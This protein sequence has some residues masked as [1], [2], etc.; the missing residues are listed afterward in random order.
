MKLLKWYSSYCFIFEI[1]FLYVR[2]SLTML[3]VI[4]CLQFVRSH[5]GLGHIKYHHKNGTNCFPAW[6]VCVSVGVW[7][8]SRTVLRPGSVWNCLWGHPLQRSPWINWKS[9]ILYPYTGFLS[10]AAWPSMLKKV[11]NGLINLRIRAPFQKE[12]YDKSQS[13]LLS[14]YI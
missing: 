10:S 13:Y 11:S 6:H 8:C 7:Q 12:S 3:L 1:C 5:P 4:A 9:R 2:I 14:L